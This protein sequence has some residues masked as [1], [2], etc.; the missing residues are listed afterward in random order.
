[1]NHSTPIIDGETHYIVKDEHTLGTIKPGMAPGL[2]N[3]IQGDVFAGGHD[4]KDGMTSCDPNI[5]N[6]RA[7]TLADFERFRVLPPPIMR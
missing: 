5:D 2:M 7:A 1:M 6:V 4:W 3:V